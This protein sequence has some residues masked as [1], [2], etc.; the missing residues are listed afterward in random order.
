MDVYYGPYA[1][2]HLRARMSDSRSEIQIDSR[3]TVQTA[4]GNAEVDVQELFSLSPDGSTIQW[5]VTRST[6]VSG[7]PLA[8]TFSRVTQ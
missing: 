1:K 5:H 3:E 6:R 7:P 2:R 8:Y 4:Q